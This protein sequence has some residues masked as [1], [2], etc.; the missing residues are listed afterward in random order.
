MLVIER[1]L[2]PGSIPRLAMRPW[3]IFTYV[4]HLRQA[5]AVAQPDERLANRTSTM[6]LALV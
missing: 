2:T 6:S 1:L 3:E 5:V 4:S